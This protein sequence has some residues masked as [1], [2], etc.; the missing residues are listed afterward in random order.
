MD[1]YDFLSTKIYQNKFYNFNLKKKYT[2]NNI[3]IY[4]INDKYKI[5]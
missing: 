1:K 2:H 3:M 4:S 5:L